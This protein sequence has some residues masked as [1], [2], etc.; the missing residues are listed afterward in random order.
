MECWDGMQ[1]DLRVPRL[2]YVDIGLTLRISNVKVDL[3]DKKKLTMH[4]RTHVELR[5]SRTYVF[6]KRPSLQI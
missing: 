3:I 6:E 4:K 5:Q 1:P 2:L